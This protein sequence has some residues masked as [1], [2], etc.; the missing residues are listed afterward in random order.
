MSG[1]GTIDWDAFTRR[2][3]EV[4]V[5]CD[6]NEYVEAAD[7][8]NLSSCFLPDEETAVGSPF[9]RRPELRGLSRLVLRLTSLLNEAHIA[10]QSTIAELKA[11]CTHIAKVAG[12]A[13][14]NTPTPLEEASSPLR[15][16]Q[17]QQQTTTVRGGSLWASLP[18]ADDEDIDGLVAAKP[19]SVAQRFAAGLFSTALDPRRTTQSTQ[20]THHQRVDGIARQLRLQIQTVH[21]RAIELVDAK[22]KAYEILRHCEKFYTRNIIALAVQ[23]GVS[24]PAARVSFLMEATIASLRAHKFLDTSDVEGILSF[25]REL[26]ASAFLDSRKTLSERRLLLTQ[27]TESAWLSSEQS[28]LNIRIGAGLT[29]LAWALSECFNNET[30]GREIWH[31][32]TFA[33]FICFGDLLLLLWMWGVSMQVWRSAGIDFVRL[34]QLQETEVYREDLAF[35]LAEGPLPRGRGGVGGHPLGRG[36]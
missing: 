36:V 14:L 9:L 15:I 33:I 3:Q 4:E 31:D 11:D 34:L 28:R 7:A 21:D 8:A 20:D 30:A 29:L 35:A 24:R 1:V 10:Q 26:Y 23:K 2:F 13:A 19:P 25:T 32:P 27:N 12:S 17:Q 16:P 22:L 6:R 5:E 18:S